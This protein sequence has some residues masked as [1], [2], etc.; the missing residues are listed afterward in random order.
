MWPPVAARI[1]ASDSF[2][3]GL[4]L[5]G[6]L[7]VGVGFSRPA[8]AAT[9]RGTEDAISL[10]YIPFSLRNNTFTVS[11]IPVQQARIAGPGSARI[12]RLFASRLLRGPHLQAPQR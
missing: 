9:R 6:T 10:R 3:G 8:Q 4:S 7:T 5:S 2:A 11:N 12:E 1:I